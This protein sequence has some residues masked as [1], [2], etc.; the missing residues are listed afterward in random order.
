MRWGV[1]G[2]LRV[3]SAEGEAVTPAGPVRRLLLAAFLSR[4]NTV[5]SAETLAS[6]V[7]GELPPRSAGKTL[8]SHLV[9]LRDDLGRDELASLL[10]TEAGGYRLRIVN[11]EFDALRFEELMSAATRHADD[12]AS[13]AMRMYDDALALWRGSA[14]EDFPDAEFL[15]PE[16]LRLA[17]LRALAEERRT[18]AALSCGMAAEVVADLERRVH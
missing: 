7:W 17:E 2:P 5:V 18:D 1:L 15:V 11:G 4:A 13:R 12:D 16:R 9:R 6:D 3:E 14:Y 8:Q 10:L